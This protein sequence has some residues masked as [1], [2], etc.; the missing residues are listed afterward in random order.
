MA[1]VVLVGRPNTGKSTLFNRLVGRRIAITLREPGITR[2]RIVRTGEWQGRRFSVIDTGGLVPGSEDEFARQIEQQVEIALREADV[3][4]LVVDGSAGLSPLDDEVAARLRKKNREFLV[5]V[6]K[7]DASRTYDASDFHRLGGTKLLT[8]SAEHGIA[9]DELLDEVVA[10]LPPGTPRT[11]RDALAIAILGRPNVGKSSF[12]N[13]LL[14][15]ERA[16]VTAIPGTTRDAI[17]EAFR[18]ED[19]DYRLI[20]TAGIRRKARVNAAVEYFSVSRAVD[21]IDRCDVALLVLDATEGPTAQDKKIANLIEDRDKGL[22]VVANKMDIVP[23]DLVERVQQYVHRQLSFVGYA[24]VVFASALE[25]QGISDAVR[26]AGRVYD[27]GGR[28]VSNALLRASVLPRLEAKPPKYNCRVTGINQ[29]GTRPPV[30]RL[31]VTEP[32]EVGA[33]YLRYVNSELRRAFGFDGY[34]VRLRLS[35]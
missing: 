9:V 23:D 20:D 15:D 30:F 25:A 33:A 31:Q 21:T 16:I 4:V 11:A 5:A 27:S 17:E 26:S 19:R 34:P 14:G 32:S 2:D 8:L 29:T 28:H 24:P 13:A 18:L 10:R 1:T 12:L 22:V 7:V 35:R 6:N 3:I